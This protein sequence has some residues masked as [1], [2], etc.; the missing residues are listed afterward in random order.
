[1]EILSDT[2]FRGANVTLSGGKLTLTD[3]GSFLPG[4]ELA[5]GPGGA[6]FRCGLTVSNLSP[7]DAYK[8]DA[9]KVDACSVEARFLNLGSV[10]LSEFTTGFF[11]NTLGSDHKFMIGTNGSVLALCVD[12]SCKFVIQPDGHIESSSTANFTRLQISHDYLYDGGNSNI[13]F[14][15]RTFVLRDQY[16]N[17][18]RL[19]SDS[20]GTSSVCGD[21][22]Y[23]EILTTVNFDNM[24]G[25]KISKLKY[26]S[27]PINF[28]VPA[29]CT[30][31]TVDVT[32]NFT[33]GN[34]LSARM[35]KLQHDV[36]FGVGQA[37]GYGASKFVDVD[38]WT[39]CTSIGKVLI[40]KSSSF[41][42]CST[43]GY[44]LKLI[45]Y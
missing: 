10:A 17:S 22:N 26:E 34:M 19:N 15:G 3:G 2:I 16:G 32:G 25:S 23:A 41:A 36:C 11:V 18:A 1:M 5:G 8:V 21:S 7:L 40:E 45:Y 44:E 29:D 30:K 13:T 38:V 43:D 28:D 12:G 20:M 24:V 14:T 33:Y 35:M 27:I 37:Q 42:M 9:Y 31:F 39:P 6:T 4:I